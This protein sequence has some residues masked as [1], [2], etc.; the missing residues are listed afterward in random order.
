MGFA[1]VFFLLASIL[2][3]VGIVGLFK[4]KLVVRWGT[5]RTRRAVL[6]YYGIPWLILVTAWG[7]TLPAAPTSVASKTAPSVG[8]STAS[9]SPKTASASKSTQNNTPHSSSNTSNATSSYIQAGDEAIVTMK[10]G[11]PMAF[12][13]D[14]YNEW[15]NDITADNTTDMQNMINNGTILMLD[16]GTHVYIKNLS[17]DGTV[18]V[19]IDNLG[20]LSG[21]TGYMDSDN[22]AAIKG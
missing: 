2:F 15:W 21:Q 22:L 5:R 4:P 20:N 10:D 14:S 18:F 19:R 6:V 8:A 13:K 3:W 1:I 16:K 12:T 9:V 7:G 17:W 11:A